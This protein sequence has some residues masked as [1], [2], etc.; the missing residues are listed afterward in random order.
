MTHYIADVAVYAHVMGNR[1]E[2][3]NASHHSLYEDYVETRTNS[4]TDDFNSFLT[5]DGTLMKVSA[6]NATM[7]L[8]YDTTFDGG[9]IFNCTWM[10]QNYNWSNPE[11]LKRCGESLN[12]AVNAITDVLHT[13][14][15]E[16][17][18]PYLNVPHSYQDNDYYCG[19]ASLQMVFDYYGE[20]IPQREIADVARTI[21]Y[22]TYTDELRRSAH[23][24]NMSTSTGTEMSTN[25]T[26]YTLR[27]L[28]YAG[29]EE[30]AMTIDDLKTL[31]DRGF[32]VIV[33]MYYDVG[34]SGHFRV[35]VGYDQ[36]HIILHDPW[37]KVPGMQYGGPDVKMNFSTFSDLWDYSGHWGLLVFPWQVSLET[38]NEAIVDD[39]FTVNA[40][41][42]YPSVYPF[43]LDPFPVSSPYAT[44]ILSNGLR[45]AEGASATLNLG[46]MRPNCTSSL[47]WNV[48]AEH[49]GNLSITIEA[50]GIISGS[51]AEKPGVGPFYT[52][53]DTIGGKTL[54]FLMVTDSSS[55]EI[56]VPTQV[57]S[58]DSVMP[59]NDVMV[60]VNITD[61]GSGVKNATVY[62]E[63]NDDGAWT[64]TEMNFNSTSQLYWA[65]IP[66]QP[67]NT[68]V[69]FRILAFDNS[70]NNASRDGPDVYFTYQVVPEFNVVIMLVPVALSSLILFSA[71]AKKKPKR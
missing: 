24:S 70:E 28:G 59:D 71:A 35:A 52:Y 50:G 29:F 12:L 26:G 32:P 53:Q 49:A 69:R 60:S 43:S 23:F 5:F 4:Y 2:W 47:C 55:P 7:A 66:G 15:L 61:P 22:V 38:P 62:Y 39:T 3:G 37:R 33:L 65:T 14:Y 10:E 48:T 25:I 45:L 40:T 9:N 67:Q 68:Q 44:I 19:P 20:R 34:G 17:Q 18:G 31:L 64:A 41:V 27:T 13:F 63:L 21:P 11:F 54:R 1:T 46:D 36:T 42:T 8:A 57:P 30:Y 58:R 56:D 51:V 6:Y 16:T